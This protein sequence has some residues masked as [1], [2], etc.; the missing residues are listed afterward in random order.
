MD[1]FQ[2]YLLK[3]E[4]VELPNKYIVDYMATPNQVQDKD[5]YQDVDGNLHREILPH[6]RSKI[7]FQ[8][9]IMTLE[10]KMEFQS[11]F[12]ER[13]T[14]PKLSIEYWNDEQNAYTTGEFYM[15]DIQFKPF[16]IIGKSMMY[17]P[18]RVAL[19]EY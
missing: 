6:T 9:P 10:E 13:K 1:E 8:T 12:P 4:G 16:M 15:P 18:F 19:I 14:N 2:G 3:I 7:E 11:H 5:S 17:K